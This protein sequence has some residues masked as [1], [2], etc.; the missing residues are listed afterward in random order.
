MNRFA[1]KVQQGL[2][3]HGLG[4]ASVSEKL[5]TVSQ[6]FHHSLMNQAITGQHLWCIDA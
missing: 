5:L 4:R 6:H 1:V 3:P 2:Q